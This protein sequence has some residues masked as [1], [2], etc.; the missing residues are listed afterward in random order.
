MNKAHSAAVKKAWGLQVPAGD[1]NS[2]KKKAIQMNPGF[3]D[4]TTKIPLRLPPWVP[5]CN[6]RYGFICQQEA[7][8]RLTIPIA[9]SFNWKTWLSLPEM[10]CTLILDVMALKQ[11]NKQQLERVEKRGGWVM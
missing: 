6:I 4:N 7:L 11:E 3:L 8:R 9:Y 1:Q 5:M 2:R 10:N